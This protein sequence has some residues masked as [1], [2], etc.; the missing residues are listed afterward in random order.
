MERNERITEQQYLE[1]ASQ[2][3]IKF[4]EMDYKISE[5]TR[6]KMSLMKELVMSYSFI[7]LLDE[8]SV[9]LVEMFDIPA[10]HIFIQ[11]LE[12][13]RERLSERVEG[14]LIR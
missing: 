12:T 6:Q 11:F 13:F 10:D 4:E 1:L 5:L 2:S 3:K 14:L 9:E 8:M 7:R